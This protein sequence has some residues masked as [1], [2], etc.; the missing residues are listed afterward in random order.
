MIMT[1]SLALL[2]QQTHLPSS[3]SVKYGLST[4]RMGMFSLAIL[5]LSTVCRSRSTFLSFAVAAVTRLNL[6]SCCLKVEIKF[7]F[8]SKKCTI[9]VF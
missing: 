4:M 1:H 7:E 2:I 5:H 8:N 6:S 9:F 3:K